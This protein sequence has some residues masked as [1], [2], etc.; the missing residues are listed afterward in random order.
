M[1]RIALHTGY[2]AVGTSSFGEGELDGVKGDGRFP[3]DFSVTLR[4]D[5][6]PNGSLAS[7]GSCDDGGGVVGSDSSLWDAVAKRKRRMVR[8]SVGTDVDASFSILGE[9]LGL[10]DDVDQEDALL[11]QLEAKPSF[12]ADGNDVVEE[13]EDDLMMQLNAISM[14]KEDEGNKN[15][16]DGDDVSFLDMLNDLESELG[17]DR[18]E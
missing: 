13:E 16:E 15:E 4:F 9:G 12:S 5:A 17:L 11:G 8:E 10:G 6:A 2:V 18:L 3:N 7:Q 14:G 1:F